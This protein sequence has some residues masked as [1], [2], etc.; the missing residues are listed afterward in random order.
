MASFLVENLVSACPSRK[1]PLFVDSWL[2]YPLNLSVRS[3]FKEFCAK[4]I[5]MQKTKVNEQ[6]IMRTGWVCVRIVVVFGGRRLKMEKMEENWAKRLLIHCLNVPCCHTVCSSWKEVHTLS[7]TCF[8]PA[9]RLFSPSLTPTLSHSF[10][11]PLLL[12]FCLSF[13]C[14]TRE[15]VWI[16]STDALH[17]VCTSAVFSFFFH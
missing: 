6:W 2:G 8:S 5:L 12:I 3:D 9:F 13:P 7:L 14:K 17:C 15:S 11:L 10:F 1:H 4:E 16:L